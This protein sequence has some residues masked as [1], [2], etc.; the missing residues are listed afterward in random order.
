M[1]MKTRIDE[2]LINVADAALRRRAKRILEE[3]EINDQDIVLDAGCGDGYFIH[4]LYSLN[5]NAVF[6]GSDFNKN[7]LKSAESNFKGSKIKFKRL[8]NDGKLLD[9]NTL[10]KGIIYLIDAD[11][12]DKLPF[13]SSS[14]SKV[15]LGEVAEHLPNDVKG[16]TEL[17]RVMKKNSTLIVTVP[18]LNYPFLWDPINWILERSTGKH[19]KN[20]FF[21]GLWYDHIRLYKPSQ[22]GRVVKKA[23]FKL[24]K[25]EAITFWC[26]PFNHHLVNLGARLLYGGKLSPSIAKSVNKY[27]KQT[28]KPLFIKSAFF[29]INAVD[30]LNNYYTPK[31]SGAGVF[32]KATK[33]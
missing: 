24:E 30:S 7:A 12:M 26:L 27:K 14:F 22:I 17:H 31:N 29:I 13:K 8:Q 23:S 4:L 28:K 10:K 20:G 1:L 2:L 6:V 33:S 11:L 15:V 9:V 21:A 16:F 3:I 5:P 19:I 18:N 25:V 32:V